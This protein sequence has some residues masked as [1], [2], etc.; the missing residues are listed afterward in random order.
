MVGVLQGGISST[1]GTGDLW[2]NVRIMLGVWDQLTTPTVTSGWIFDAPSDEPRLVG[3]GLRRMIRDRTHLIQYRLGPAGIL[4]DSRRIKL[5]VKFRKPLK[6]NWYQLGSSSN[7]PGNRLVLSM[8]S[9]SSVIPNPGFV[10]GWWLLKY[11]DV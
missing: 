2:N 6:I 7:L 8:L 1:T 11:R 3:R 10:S 4:P 5:R 9:D